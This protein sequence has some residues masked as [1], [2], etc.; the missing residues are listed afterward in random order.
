MKFEVHKNKPITLDQFVSV[1]RRSNIN[2]PVDDSARM[3]AMMNSSNLIVS[4]WN[5]EELIGLARCFIDY[6]WVCYLSDLLVDVKYQK[7][8]VGKLLINK[9]RDECGDECQLILLSALSAMDYYPKAGF[10][11]AGHAFFIKRKRI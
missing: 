8:G 1:Y 4:A 7:N 6:A 10:E 5:N 11:Q 9:V 3:Q 2:R